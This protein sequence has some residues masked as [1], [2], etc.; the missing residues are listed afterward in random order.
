MTKRQSF[1]GLGA[2]IL[3]ANCALAADKVYVDLKQKNV[4]EFIEEMV[5]THDFERDALAAVLA[6]AEI[7]ANIIKKIST[8]AE[9]TLT[10]GEYRK[11]FITPERVNAGA[12]F[13]AGK[14]GNAGSHC[15]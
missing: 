6:R 3:I 1:T 2:L 10:W 11:I 12:A 14:Q 4:V 7:K 15:T 8:P 13:L 5:Q 9:R